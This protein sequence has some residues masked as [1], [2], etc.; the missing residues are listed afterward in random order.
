MMGLHYYEYGSLL[1]S[2]TAWICVKIAIGKIISTKTSLS[3]L[4]SVIRWNLKSQTLSDTYLHISSI[5]NRHAYYT[6]F[7]NTRTNC[8]RVC[9]PS[10]WTLVLKLCLKVHFN[11]TT[12]YLVHIHRLVKSFDILTNHHLLCH[13]WLFFCQISTNKKRKH[14]WHDIDTTAVDTIVRAI[15][16]TQGRTL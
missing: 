2:P 12:N 11:K 5:W 9:R 8:L 15:D 13:V 10:S 16:T 7:L 3:R 1:L 6:S 14:Y 4:P